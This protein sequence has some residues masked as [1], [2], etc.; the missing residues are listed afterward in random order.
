MKLFEKKKLEEH[1]LSNW[2]KFVDYKVLNNLVIKAI[3]LYANNWATI[4]IARNIKT[5]KIFFSKVE[6]ISTGEI[7]LW[8]SF[9]IPYNNN[10]AVGTLELLTNPL[11]EYK[12]T[13]MSGNF[14]Y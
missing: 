5:Q 11:G 2:T 7:K 4:Q 1:L 14:Y 13:Q 8:I 12:V 10:T 6:I 3:P 9:E